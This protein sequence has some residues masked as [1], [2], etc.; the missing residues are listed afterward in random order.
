M[1]MRLILGVAIAA[2][3]P[4]LPAEARGRWTEAQ[5]RIWLPGLPTA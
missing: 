2:M 4:A 5:A 3:L 1:R